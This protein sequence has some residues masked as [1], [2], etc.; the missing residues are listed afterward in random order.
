MRHKVLKGAGG[1]LLQP[2]YRRAARVKQAAL[3][4]RADVR[5]G[6]DAV[7]ARERPLP[8]NS[9]GTAAGPTSQGDASEP[10]VF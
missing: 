7:G 5:L 9:P 1:K 6:R 4:L 3:A 8:V 10:P 2:G